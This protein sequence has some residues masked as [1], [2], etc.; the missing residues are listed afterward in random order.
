[1][2]S[3]PDGPQPFCLFSSVQGLRKLHSQEHVYRRALNTT[4]LR[5]CRMVAM[6]PLSMCDRSLRNGWLGFHL[7][8]VGLIYPEADEDCS[9][10]DNLYQFCVHTNTI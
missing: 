7:E 8:A 1:M 9:S 6:R 2:L 10:P 5:L 3:I 4:V